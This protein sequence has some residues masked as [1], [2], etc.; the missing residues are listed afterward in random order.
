MNLPHTHVMVIFALVSVCLS[1]SREFSVQFKHSREI[2]HL[3]V[4]LR[5][6]EWIWRKGGED[7]AQVSERSARFGNTLELPTRLPVPSD[8]HPPVCSFVI[9]KNIKAQVIGT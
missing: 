6:M 9:H 2:T 1:L 7:G 8:C 5:E 4:L 3:H